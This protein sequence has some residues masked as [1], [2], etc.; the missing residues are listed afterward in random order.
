MALLQQW[1]KFAQEKQ[2]APD[3]GLVVR[4]SFRRNT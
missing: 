2:N 1:E 4:V 3:G